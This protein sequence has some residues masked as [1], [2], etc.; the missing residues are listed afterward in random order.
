LETFPT[1]LRALYA[2]IEEGVRGDLWDS[3]DAC[4]EHYR[5]PGRLEAYAERAYKNSIASLK[6]MALLEHIDP[7]LAIVRR[8][9]SECAGAAGIDPA[10]L[11]EYLDDLVEFCRLRRRNLLDHRG[12]EGEGTFR[13]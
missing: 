8:A 4:L 9:T 13:F 11:E 6:A 1:G 12:D 5:A 2:A 10:S 3:R 7:V